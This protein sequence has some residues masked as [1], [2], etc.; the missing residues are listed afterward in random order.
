MR[1]TTSM[2]P[3]SAYMARLCPVAPMPLGWPA[4]AAPNPWLGGL[5]LRLAWRRARMVL[6]AFCGQGICGEL[7]CCGGRD[8]LLVLSSVLRRRSEDL[9][10]LSGVRACDCEV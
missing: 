8:L 2:T 10:A 3:T 4:G 5:M 9:C 1:A 7:R 6:G